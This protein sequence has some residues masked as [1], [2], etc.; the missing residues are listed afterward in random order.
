MSL[1][2]QTTR[3]LHEAL[4]FGKQFFIFLHEVLHLC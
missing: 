1:R 2:I 3:L 4:T